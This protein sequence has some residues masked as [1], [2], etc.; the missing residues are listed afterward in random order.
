MDAL[1]AG[2][3][4][5]SI[6]EWNVW[7]LWLAVYSLCV[8]HYLYT[9]AAAA[10]AHAHTRHAQVRHLPGAGCQV[11]SLSSVDEFSLFR[12]VAELLAAD[13]G[14]AAAQRRVTATELPLPGSTSYMGPSSAT[15]FV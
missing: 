11:T 2:G 12:H 7:W 8:A 1:Q 5:L 14:D 15:A 9:R 4:S 10:S 13:E 6:V 3:V